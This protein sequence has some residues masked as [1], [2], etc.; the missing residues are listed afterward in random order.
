MRDCLQTVIRI[1]R[2]DSDIAA[3][4]KQH[5]ELESNNRA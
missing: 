3:L 1:A 5:D 4:V 2:Y